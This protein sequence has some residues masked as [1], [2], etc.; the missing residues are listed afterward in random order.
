MAFFEGVHA[1]LLF[2]VAAAVIAAVVMLRGLRTSLTW[3]VEG[4]ARIGELEREKLGQLAKI[5]AGGDTNALSTRISEL[6][7]GFQGQRMLVADAVDRVTALSNRV[8]ARQRRASADLDP[9]EEPETGPTPEQ[10]AALRKLL[11]GAPAPAAQP[12]NGG[13]GL[14]L[15]ERARRHRAQRGE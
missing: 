1:L 9:D 14:S 11:E 7:T 10:A 2:L 5:G 4:V 13:E 15:K 8:A 3:L 6:E 12:G